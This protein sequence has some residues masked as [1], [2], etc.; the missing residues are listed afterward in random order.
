MKMIIVSFLSIVLFVPPTISFYIP[1]V[2]PQN[3]EKGENVEVKVSDRLA[4]D[5][6]FERVIHLGSENDQY[7]N[8]I[9]L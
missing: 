9:T 5:R 6:S 1:G 8:A 3:F 7:E 2:A 4:N